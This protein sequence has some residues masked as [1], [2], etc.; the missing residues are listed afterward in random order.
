MQILLN[1]TTIIIICSLFYGEFDIASRL[2]PFILISYLLGKIM[3]W[4]MFGIIGLT[5]SVD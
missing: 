3:Q 2:F 5:N 4:V 1:V